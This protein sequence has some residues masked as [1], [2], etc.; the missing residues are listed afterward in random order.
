MASDHSLHRGAK[1]KPTQNF[2]WNHHCEKFWTFT[3]TSATLIM[4]RS[5]VPQDG[6]SHD[7]EEPCL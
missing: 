3:H 2:I 4:A 1:E 6:A 5:V 7:P